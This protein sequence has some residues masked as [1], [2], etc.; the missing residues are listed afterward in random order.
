MAAETRRCLKNLQAV[1]RSAG[2]DLS[3]VLRCTVY[4]TDL[5]DFAELNSVY[6]EF[7]PTTPPGR[8]TVQVAALPRGGGVEIDAIAEQM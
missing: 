1:L 7:F 8:T 6:S 4:V 5:G 2:S 3:K